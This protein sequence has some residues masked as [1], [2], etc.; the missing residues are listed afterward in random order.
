MTRVTSAAVAAPAAVH[1][2]VRTSAAALAGGWRAAGG[3]A[4][5]RRA[6]F[7]PCV[8]AAAPSVRLLPPPLATARAG[9]LPVLLLRAAPAG[10]RSAT[11]VCTAV[12]AARAR[13]ALCDASCGSQISKRVALCRKKIPANAKVATSRSVATER[14]QRRGRGLFCR[15]LRCARI[16]VTAYRAA[17]V[18]KG[19]G[20]GHDAQN[21]AE[22]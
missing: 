17:R 9:G 13:A 8:R 21:F 7:A 20:A 4:T 16:L 6:E 18:A 14:R 15:G 22:V 11:A 19:M 5:V 3:G 2:S 1:C 10:R 12:A